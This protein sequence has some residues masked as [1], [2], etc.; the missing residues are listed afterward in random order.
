MLDAAKIRITR[1][2]LRHV[3]FPVLALGVSMLIG[4]GVNHMAR[5]A[6]SHWSQ[7][8]K[9]ASQPGSEL[10]G[11][12]MGAELMAV[13]SIGNQPPT[14]RSSFA[15]AGRSSVNANVT[16][17]VAVQQIETPVATAVAVTPT[18][19]KSPA[20][21]VTTSLEAAI[22][23]AVMSHADRVSATTRTTEAAA[24]PTLPEGHRIFNGRVIRP[25]RTITMVTTAYSPD[26]RSC[27]PNADGTT[28]SGKSVW[29]NG[30][31]MA[32]ADTRMLPFGTIISVPGYYDG[33][34]V[35]VLDRGGAIKGH[36]LDML[37]PTHE[38]ALQWG[39]KTQKVVV[40]EYVD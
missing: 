14:R 10:S 20:P 2:M 40:W 13:E 28:A 27:G 36:R 9:N 8:N 24:A 32:A 37:Y 25:A 17:P 21:T 7:Q 26:E 34:P 22:T 31:K 4:A 16:A 1:N 39:R 30:M 15:M 19:A 33:Q 12:L 35:P 23:E 11:R 29:T 3:G 6:L 18:V 38:V 5:P